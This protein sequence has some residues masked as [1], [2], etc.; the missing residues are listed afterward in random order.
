MK[1]PC[2]PTRGQVPVQTGKIPQLS[3]CPQHRRKGPSIFNALVQI[4]S[5]PTNPFHYDAQ[6]W[7][8]MTSPASQD[9]PAVIQTLRPS[10]KENGGMMKHQTEEGDY[11]LCTWGLPDR[12]LSGMDKQARRNIGCP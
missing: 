3:E 5:G 1:K 6:M 8:P 11:P 2:A 9:V 4:Y 10:N 7:L 12:G